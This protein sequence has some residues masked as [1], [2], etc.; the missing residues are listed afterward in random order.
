MRYL[1]RKFFLFIL[2]NLFAFPSFSQYN[3]VRA[4]V[5]GLLSNLPVVRIAYE[6]S[7]TKAFSVGL[8]FEAGK[9]ASTSTGSLGGPMIET[10][11]VTGWGLVPEIRF[12]PFNSYKPAPAG[13][14]I[15]SHY[16]FRSLKE[17]SDIL[18]GKE[19]P[20]GTAYNFGVNA[21]YKIR[22]SQFIMDIVLG[23]GPSG[24]K[25]R[26]GSGEY[27]FDHFED[28]MKIE[29]SLGFVFPKM[30]WKDKSGKYLYLEGS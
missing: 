3:V 5:F 19:I 20:R 9:Y 8:G 11:K 28:R 30:P 29:F 1:R 24:G 17:S 26:N 7:L 21:G 12:Y 13:F 25:W 23:Y 2:V 22:I 15:G 14:F 27:T 4:D 6:R 16:R 18:Q 10:Y